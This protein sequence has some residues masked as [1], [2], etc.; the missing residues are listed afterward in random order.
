MRDTIIQLNTIKAVGE[1]ESFDQRSTNFTEKEM[2]TLKTIVSNF[3]E[4]GYLSLFD[5]VDYKEIHVNEDYD[6][7]AIKIVIDE[8]DPSCYTEIN[9][10]IEWIEQCDENAIEA[11]ET[12]AK[13]FF[14]YEFDKNNADHVE[15]FSDWLEDI[16]GGYQVSHIQYIPFVKE[17]YF[18]KN[19]ADNELKNYSYRYHKNA[20]IIERK[21]YNDGTNVLRKLLSLLNL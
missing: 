9:N 7:E 13:G 12:Y 16:R 5:L 19:E 8:H 18:D 20:K 21:I 17:T 4:R 1:E 6:E 10:L 3:N 14:D 11:F 2:A 15:E